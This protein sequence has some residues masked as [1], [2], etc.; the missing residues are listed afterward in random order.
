MNDMNKNILMVLAIIVALLAGLLVLTVA[1]FE[2]QAEMDVV[3]TTTSRVIPH[4]AAEPDNKAQVSVYVENPNA[5]VTNEHVSTPTVSV[6]V[7]E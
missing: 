2:P 4:P 7:V 3:P 5:P 1:S 6:R